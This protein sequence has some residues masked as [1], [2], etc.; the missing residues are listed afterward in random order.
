MDGQKGKEDEQSEKSRI[1]AN[2]Q[3]SLCA[4]RLVCNRLC[5]C[6][7]SS[8][9]PFLP[10]ISS[11]FCWLSPFSPPLTLYLTPDR[12]EC[13]SR[14]LE[15]PL[16]LSPFI[17]PCLPCLPHWGCDSSVLGAGCWTACVVGRRRNGFDLYY[18]YIAQGPAA[19][20]SWNERGR[21]PSLYQLQHTGED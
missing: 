10:A 15:A 19:S 6:I 21:L 9:C 7:S 14:C 8:P 4:S 1:L 16:S 20:T 3:I 18:G 12:A 17:H 5:S 2:Q 13:R 11:C